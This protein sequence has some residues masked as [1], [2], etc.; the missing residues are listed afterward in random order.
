MGRRKRI[1]WEDESIVGGFRNERE[2]Q[3]RAKKGKTF[4]IRVME[5]AFS[6]RQHKIN[7]I[8]E[9]D[10]DGEERAFNMNCSKDWD[11]EAED[12]TGDCEGCEREYDVVERFIA[13]ILV[14]GYYSGRSDKFKAVDADES[15]HY[16][17]FGR[18]QYRKIS[19]LALSMQRGKKKRALKTVELLVTC[20]DENFQK[21]NLN[22]A[23]PDDERRTT[24]E[25]VEAWKEQ[26]DDL[27]DLATEAPKKSEWQRRLKK[28]KPA[29]KSRSRDRDDDGEDGEDE[30]PKRRAKKKKPAR[31][32]SEPE[33]D[34]DDG[35]GSTGDEEIDD[36]LAEL[37]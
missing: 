12:W 35:D 6:F 10:K 27:L 17:D 2:R 5:D 18:T 25:H 26:G 33:D 21:I 36:L 23:D 1:G 19:D 30:A 15:P 16:W 32:K 4:V 8:L 9:P 13:G 14:L 29:K 31:R 37:D 11:D 34:A 20:E 28:K 22:K 3:F 7:D 24:R